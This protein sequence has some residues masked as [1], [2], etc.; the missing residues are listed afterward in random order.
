MNNFLSFFKR[1]PAKTISVRE[2]LS[3]LQIGSTARLKFRDP[4]KSGFIDPS[5]S[6]SLRFDEDDLVSRQLVGTVLLKKNL[7]GLLLLEIGCFKVR[8]GERRE[9]VYTLLAEEI[10]TI[11]VV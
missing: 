7:N 2:Q 9:R 6:M 1:K 11:E 4:K 5:G 8:N 10:E 3:S